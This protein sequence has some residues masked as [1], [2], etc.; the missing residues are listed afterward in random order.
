MYNMQSLG[1][2]R[3]AQLALL[4]SKKWLGFFYGTQFPVL[5]FL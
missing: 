1:F 3:I 4:C 5:Q 2:L